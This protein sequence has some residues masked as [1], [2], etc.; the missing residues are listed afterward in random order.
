LL[1]FAQKFY[2][3][4]QP[5]PSN[6]GLS[7]DNMTEFNTTLGRYSAALTAATTPATRTSVTV[8]QKK[9]HKRSLINACRMLVNIC[10]A[11]PQMTNDKRKELGIHVRKPRVNR[12][13]VPTI[14]PLLEVEQVKANVVGVVAR[15]PTTGR[16][17]FPSGVRGIAVYTHVGDEAP[18]SP[19]EMRF[20][21]AGTDSKTL[22]SFP[23]TLAPFTKVWISVCYT[24]PRG[25]AGPGSTPTATNLGTWSV[26]NVPAKQ[27]N[28]AQQDLKIAA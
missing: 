7:V 4:A 10:N 16:R 3:T 13:P 20:E 12:L 14:A 21:G 1:N 11:W 15:N 17:A 23:K 24:N 27:G 9:I 2:D 25:Q 26:Q 18:A 5:A 28:P 8:E 19:D 6:F 22:V